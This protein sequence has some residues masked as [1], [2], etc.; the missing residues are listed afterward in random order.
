MTHPYHYLPPKC[1]WRSAVSERAV[2]EIEQ[3]WTPKFHVEQNTVIS[4]AGS[5]FAQ[6]FSKALVKRDYNWQNFESGPAFLT[7]EQR[8]DYHYG[9]FS[10]RTGNIYTVRMMRQWLE[11]AFGIAE[12]SN[13][14]WIKDDRYFDPFRPSVEPEGFHSNAE[15]DKSR[16]EC[17]KAIR[18]A[19]TR[20]QVF[21]FTLGLTE[22][23]ANCETGVEYAICPGAVAGEYDL[24]NHEFINHGFSSIAEDLE[25]VLQLVTSKNPEIRVLLTVSP[26]P[27]TATACDEHV[28]VATTYSKSVLRAVIGQFVSTH[29]VD[30]FPSYEIFT[31]PFT[32]GAFYN[33]NLRTVSQTGVDFAMDMF[34]KEQMRTFGGLTPTLDV[35]SAVPKVTTGVLDDSD[36]DIRC[37][38]EL[39]AAF[40]PSLS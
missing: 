15:L 35:R 25:A 6:H 29:D 34:F 19:I 26:V 9:T 12:P 30:Y 36:S 20:S 13:E 40:G 24:K 28:V 14:V 22:S 8:T 17:L 5:C 10:F 33:D 38:E 18:D 31:S 21:V 4:T 2:H 11:W 27:L 3:F 16:A 32:R 37:E 23:W 39:L 1:F 7:P